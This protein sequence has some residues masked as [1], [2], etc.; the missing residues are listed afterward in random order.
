MGLTN[1][2]KLEIIARAK[3]DNYTG[4][5]LDL[6]NQAAAEGRQ[7]MP[8]VRRAGGFIYDVNKPDKSTY[9]DARSGYGF[10]T[11]YE[12][13]GVNNNEL[14]PSNDFDLNPAITN[15]G[16][17]Y[18]SPE[19]R[20]RL[21]TE[22]Q[23]AHG[24]T[25]TDQQIDDIVAQNMQNINRG[26]NTALTDLS[27]ADVPQGTMGYADLNTGQIA[28]NTSR[29]SMS[30]PYATAVH[31]SDYQPKS[32]LQSTAE[33]EVAHRANAGPNSAMTSASENPLNS[34]LD[35][36]YSTF[37][38][39]APKDSPY[40]PNN[41]GEFSDYATQPIEVKSQKKQME[42]A[43]Q[44]AGIWNPTEGPFT[45]EHIKKLEL[46]EYKVEPSLDYMNR[47]LNIPTITEERAPR[48]ASQ[49]TNYYSGDYG[50]PSDIVKKQNEFKDKNSFRGLKNKLNDELVNKSGKSVN[51]GYER[52]IINNNYL[53]Q[54]QSSSV[55]WYSESSNFNM[56]NQKLVD[57]GFS[58][59]NRGLAQEEAFNSIPPKQQEALRY[60][61]DKTELSTPED[62]RML[63]L[64]QNGM[65]NIDEYYR[66][67]Y[68]QQEREFDSKAREEG[69]TNEKLLQQEQGQ[70]YEKRKE[71]DEN[72]INFMN[73]VAMDNPFEDQT[74]VA[75]QGG[76]SR[77]FKQDFSKYI[78]KKEDGGLHTEVTDF[79]AQNPGR[80]LPPSSL[81]S[82]QAIT[83]FDNFREGI[84]KYDRQ[85]IVPQSF[86]DAH[87]IGGDV[88]RVP[89]YE[90]GE[91]IMS[92]TYNN[93]RS[94]IEVAPNLYVYDG[95]TNK[96]DPKSFI[97]IDDNPTT[98]FTKS[99]IK[100]VKKPIPVPPR[101]EPRAAGPIP[102]NTG[103]PELQ[104]ATMPEFSDTGPSKSDLFFENL[105]NAN[106][107]KNR[108]DKMSDRSA[109]NVRGKDDVSSEYIFSDDNPYA[110]QKGEY[111]M[112]EANSR[113]KRKYDGDLNAARKWERENGL[114]IQTDLKGYDVGP[115][116]QKHGGYKSIKRYEHGGSH[117]DTAP[118]PIGDQQSM[119]DNTRVPII[120]L[121]KITSNEMPSNEVAVNPP[122]NERRQFINFLKEQEAG[123]EFM[124]SINS[125]VK[126]PD[127]TYYKAFEDGKFYPY[128]QGKEKEA[129]IGYGRK[130][131]NVLEKYNKGITEQEAL[132]FMNKDIDRSL[133]LAK[134]Y[135]E[136][137][138]N[139][140]LYGDIGSF[141]RL[142]SNTQYLLSDYTYNV[143]KLSKF[144][145][146]TKAV[147]TNDPV[148]MEEE[149]IR[150]ED[151]STNI[152]LK[153][154]KPFY[155]LYLKPRIDKLKQNNK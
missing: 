24:V 41:S 54:G 53:P 106:T 105:E 15:V 147:L 51:F 44:D 107:F 5:Y 110:P 104:K 43:L 88:R 131:A 89:Y 122:V 85:R 151:K 10:P 133:S 146:F 126:K 81:D 112:S 69:R 138:Q 48:N 46:S 50:S 80:Y 38:T 35:Q 73:G 21:S 14:P 22:Y 49:S 75:K 74:Q 70:Y 65:S 39:N 20:N 42:L 3:K 150:V 78:N 134:E 121:N 36:Y 114:G 71:V 116:I 27:G 145:N 155:D 59:A 124:R 117:D 144:P 84:K 45:Q 34:E 136:N 7:K 28:I 100:G 113:G 101:I 99:D 76:F 129:T 135:V 90:A 37:F 1:R 118:L 111:F 32:V 19:Y 128:F 31:K 17:I 64:A 152:P 87:G 137:N 97:F 9:V 33:H 130:A 12:N 6:F 58:S 23:Q 77:M 94:N 13:G 142:D 109:R 82:L 92:R 119:L 25:L 153:R 60:I 141:G 72:L 93:E 61:A 47:G 55:E 123:P 66:T 30:N 95:T 57:E 67:E 115:D 132:G 86:K 11:T 63:K 125:A 120:N 26:G 62:L 83:N 149:Y 127:G 148:G 2:E 103:E 96:A 52:N 18:Q 79:E 4:N 16:N 68:K 91:G 56:N 154:N 98:A 29:P 139:S 40:N 102:T 143:G 140:P 8:E 108:P